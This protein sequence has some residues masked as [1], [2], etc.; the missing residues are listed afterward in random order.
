MLFEGQLYEKRHFFRNNVVMDNIDVSNLFPFTLYFVLSKWQGDKHITKQEYDNHVDESITLAK[1]DIDVPGNEHDDDTTMID[2]HM[3]QMV[4]GV[5]ECF[6]TNPYVNSENGQ[7][8]SMD[9][10]NDI[11]I[12]RRSQSHPKRGG[13]Q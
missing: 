11:A 5:Y 2:D 3:V 1:N 9:E 12:K 10:I 13:F 6:N 8:S 7:A 4:N